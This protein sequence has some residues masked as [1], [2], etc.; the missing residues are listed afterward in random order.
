MN[1]LGDWTTQAE[2]PNV[3]LD[4]YCHVIGSRL[5]QEMRVLREVNDVIG[6]RLTQETRLLREMN[7]VVACRL[8]QETRVVREVSDVTGCRLTQETKVLRKVNDVASESAWPDPSALFDALG[9]R[10]VKQRAREGDR[11]GLT[12]VHF[13]AQRK[14]FLCDRGCR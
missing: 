3:G 2:D 5:T 8:T 10:I 12:L 11:Q 4:S 6:C 14:R 9:D 7:D 1:P 13:S